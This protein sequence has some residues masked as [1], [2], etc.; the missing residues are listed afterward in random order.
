MTILTGQTAVNG[1]AGAC[2][3]IT[4][5]G[6]FR[7][8]PYTAIGT[9]PL[10][11]IDGTDGSATFEGIVRPNGLIS[12]GYGVFNSSGS[13]ALKVKRDRVAS[14]QSDVFILDSGDKEKQV[15]FKTDGSAS[16]A[17]PSTQLRCNKVFNIWTNESA[18]NC[19]IDGSAASNALKVGANNFLVKHDGSTLLAGGIWNITGDNI[20]GASN[21]SNQK[22]VQLKVQTELVL[23][24][25]AVGQS[26]E[27]FIS[28]WDS[29]GNRFKVTKDGSA[30]F[31]GDPTAK[32]TFLLE[33]MR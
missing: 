7:L 14:T 13:Y 5:T 33:V 21:N 23:V 1:T 20:K 29:T 11:T 18:C 4:S 3:G 10:V 16:F 25:D 17:A 30:E 24:T 6:E 19:F 32:L 9:A 8:A 28:C 15:V 27:N 22:Y 31:A 26:N 2:M 12:S